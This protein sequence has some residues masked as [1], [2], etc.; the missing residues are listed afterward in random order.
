MEL[1]IYLLVVIVR[2]FLTV[3]ELLFLFRA[4]L[5][6]LFMAEDGPV[7]NFLYAVTE[8]LI[9]PIRKLLDRFESI[10][11]LPIDIPFL[12]A[13]ILLSVIQMLLPTVYL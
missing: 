11:D 1:L 8:P 6:W 7:M 4:I 3:E 5:S 10:R 13:V 12:V 2:L 9:I